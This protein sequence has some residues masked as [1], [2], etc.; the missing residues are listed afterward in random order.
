MTIQQ[1][2]DLA[3]E[4]GIKA[5]PR[6]EEGVKKYLERA[7]KTYDELPDKKKKFF[8]KE[9]L[10]N[11]Y[12]DSRLLVGD[13]KREVKRVLA[14]IDADGTE[15]L[16]ADR[17]T[18]KGQTIDLL[19]SHHPE[20]HAYANLHEV[21]EL[22]VDMYAQM[23]MPVNIADSLMT[24]R[25]KDIE[26]RIHPANHNQVVD[27][28]KLLGVPLLACHTIQDN[29]SYKFMM[30]YLEGKDFDTVG[31]LYNHLME[32]PEYQE[33]TMGKAGPIIISGSEKSRAGKIAVFFTGGT[34]PSK[35]LYIEWAKLGYG[36]II[37][38]HMK[39]DVVAEM[40]KMH[41]NVINAGHI[42]SDSIGANILFDELER[43]GIEVIPCS[44]LI[45]VKRNV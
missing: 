27:T 5:D 38:M 41:I 22:Q 42:S 31:E 35:E 21:M 19:I 12:S 24:K 43:K 17:L 33:A 28:A 1:I 8:D 13:P 15:V 32:I 4:M 20:G 44:G 6:G 29:L 30:D 25:M 18:Q 39:D 26:L 3:I 10:K 40:R 9:V 23:G 2:Y 36:T 16:L 45:R 7:K 11:P 37:D 34:N 14:G